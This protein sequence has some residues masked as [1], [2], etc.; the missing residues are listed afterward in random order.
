MGPSIS[1]IF[2]KKK[3]NGRGEGGVVEYP[4][5]IE[6]LSVLSNYGSYC[7]PHP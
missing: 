4:V 3:K 1:L 6:F 2:Q 5:D 7:A